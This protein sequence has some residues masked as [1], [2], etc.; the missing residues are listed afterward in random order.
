MVSQKEERTRVVSGKGRKKEGL[1][2]KVN[3]ER[4]E[5]EKDWREVRAKEDVEINKLRSW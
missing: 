1:K 4:K 2:K 3:E 5:P